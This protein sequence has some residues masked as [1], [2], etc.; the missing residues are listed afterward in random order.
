MHQ[1]L[2]TFSSDRKVRN[3]FAEIRRFRR[4]PLSILLHNTVHQPV[5]KVGVHQVQSF[6]QSI[7]K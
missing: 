5:L 6:K 7:S 4:H 3:L 2:A 1:D